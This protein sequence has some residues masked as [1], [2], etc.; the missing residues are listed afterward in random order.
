MSKDNLSH[1]ENCQANAR[2]ISFWAMKNQKHFEHACQK[3]R[4]R[5]EKIHRW[6]VLLGQ[7]VHVELSCKLVVTT[8]A[9]KF[10]GELSCAHARGQKVYQWIV[11]HRANKIHHWNWLSPR[12]GRFTAELSWVHG[13]GEAYALGFTGA[14][15]V[16][17]S[18]KNLKL[19][20]HLQQK[21]K[22]F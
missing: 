14:G 17:Q 12:L 10:T 8:L 9:Q 13:R 2:Q 20:L 6:I 19:E 16:I 18:Q 21:G 4:L 3:K 1:L 11:W 5:T 7:K 15:A 22:I